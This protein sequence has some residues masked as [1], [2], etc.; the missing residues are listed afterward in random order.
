MLQPLWNWAILGVV[1]LGIEMLTGTFYILWFGIAAL[2][3]ALLTALFPTTSLAMQLLAFSV[4]ALTSL[5]VWRSKY[6]QLA[7]HSRV[8][9]S[10]DDTIGKRGKITV[11]VSS[12]Q[13]GTIAFTVPVMSSREWTAI[14]DERIAAGE[15]AE[16]IAV[17]GN[18]LRVRRLPV[19][20]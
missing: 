16:V 17:E 15:E 10:R 8:G 19:N 12:E 11:A 5:A 6:K 14:S 20:L 9:Q 7:P 1:L 2:C 4:L 3:V 18:F 13:N